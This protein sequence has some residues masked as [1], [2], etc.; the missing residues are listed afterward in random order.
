[1]SYVQCN[2]CNAQNHR[3]NNPLSMITGSSVTVI[4]SLHNVSYDTGEWNNSIL[5]V[6]ILVTKYGRRVYYA[7][8]NFLSVP[9]TTVI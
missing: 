3:L 2:K 9:N 4:G 5:L 8:Q 1:M 6:A 7:A